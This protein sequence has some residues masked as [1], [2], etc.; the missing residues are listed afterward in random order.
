[1]TTFDNEQ[2]F[3]FL[4]NFIFPFSRIIALIFTAPILGDK[5]V[6]Y[7]IKI[8]LSLM[9]TV[10]LTPLLPS[11]NITVIE[12]HS[13]LIILQQIVIGIAL[14]LTMQFIF[15]VTYISGEML[16]LQMGLSFSN[17]FDINNHNNLSII[18]HFFNIFIYLFFLSINGHFFFLDALINTFYTIPID[19]V[20]FHPNMLLEIVI[21]YNVVFVNGV[22]LVFPII[23]MILILNIILSLLNRVLPQI[24]IFSI[25][26]P[27]TLLTG[28]FMLNILMSMSPI[29]TNNIFRNLLQLL[30]F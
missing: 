12:I 18:S 7:K 20:I 1:M 6:N 8:L 10:L 16:G 23:F 28:I 21:L 27:I 30:I 29:I 2:Y 22:M 24:S 9:I 14:G 25:V 11:L 13:L 3:S 15:S 26:F 4:I 5:L 17:F 19:K